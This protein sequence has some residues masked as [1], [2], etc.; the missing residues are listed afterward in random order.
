MII[1]KS[2]TF[3]IK[4]SL[5][6]F[7]VT[8]IL[9]LLSMGALGGIL[10]YP[11]S[12]LFAPYPNINDWHGDWVWPT[13]IMVGMLWSF[14]FVF[15]AVAWYYLNKISDSKVLLISVYVA[16]LW[17]WAALLWAGMI[18]VNVKQLT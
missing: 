4:F 15:A 2:W 1:W 18:M 6:A 12:F 9:G 11:V 17:L 8:A 7:F 13:L 3:N 5:I 14:G 10:Y 16:I